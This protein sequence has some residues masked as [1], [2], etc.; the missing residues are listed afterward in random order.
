M[1]WLCATSGVGVSENLVGCNGDGCHS[2]RPLMPRGGLAAVSNAA[3]IPVLGRLPFDPRMA[4]CCDRGVIF[5]REYADT[6]LARQLTALAQSID[7]AAIP[8]IQAE[9]PAA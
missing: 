3:G 6:P 5:I 1:G 8:R 4:E 7:L 2:V 9:M